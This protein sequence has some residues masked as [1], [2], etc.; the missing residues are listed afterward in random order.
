MS[1]LQNLAG[2]GDMTEQVIASDFLISIKSTIQNYAIAISETT[3]PEVREVLGR[4]LNAAIDTH[5]KIL[6]FM[7]KDTVNLSYFLKSTL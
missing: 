5:E 2:L 6:S 4:H 7:N 1:I 3:T